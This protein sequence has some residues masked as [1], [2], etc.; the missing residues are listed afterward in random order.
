[1]DDVLKKAQEAA[2]A[3]QAPMYVF[4]AVGLNGHELFWF[5]Q[6]GKR[7]SSSDEIL[8]VIEPENN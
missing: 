1:M 3:A 7:S 2:N 8:Q 5:N 6:T 4:R